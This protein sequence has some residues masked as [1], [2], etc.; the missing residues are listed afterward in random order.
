RPRPAWRPREGYLQ[1]KVS[2]VQEMVKRFDVAQTLVFGAEAHFSASLNW[3]PAG[4]ADHARAADT[5]V[6]ATSN[7]QLRHSTQNVGFAV[8]FKNQ[9]GASAFAAKGAQ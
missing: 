7:H 5:S 1:R 4:H 3:L 2:A 9:S 6:C 8:S